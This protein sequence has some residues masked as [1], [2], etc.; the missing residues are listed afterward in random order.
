MY[1]D[2]K[3]EKCLLGRNGYIKLSDF[4]PAMG[5]STS[6]TFC[7]TPEYISPEM[8]LG[9]GHDHTADWWALGVLTYEMLTGVL[10]FYDK[11]RNMMI[12]NIK[13]AEIKW[14]DLQ[15]HSFT[16]STIAKDFILKLLNRESK[17]RL[18]ARGLNEVMSHPFLSHINM[19]DLLSKKIEA[20]FIPSVPNLNELVENQK[21]MPKVT[22]LRETEVPPKEQKLVGEKDLNFF[23]SFG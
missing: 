21:F 15:Q 19:P 5:A 8:I 4:G 18:G 9:Q 3:P 10:P 13:Q 23:L 6:N 16:V 22:E 12:L 1:R 2:L 11:N 14:P 7:G 17:Q 20:P